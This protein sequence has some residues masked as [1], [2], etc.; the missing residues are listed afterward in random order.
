[1]RWQLVLP[2]FLAMKNQS[3]MS[4]FDFF[5]EGL[6]D[7]RTVGTISRSS[8][9]VSKKMIS[10][11]DFK[12]AK[13]IVELGA[14]DGPITKYILQAMGP[15]TKLLAFEINSKLCE[16]M[17]QRFAGDKRLVVIEDSAENIDKHIAALGFDAADY[18][19][20]ALPFVALPEE[21]GDS[22]LAESRDALRPGGRFIQLNYSLIPRKRY[23]KVFGNSDIAFVPINIP[24]AWVTVC[25][26]K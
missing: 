3:T 2:F 12:T 6:K 14:G 9:F 16:I 20:S 5:M 1:L 7:I 8:K 26:K 23:E 15:D 19:I 13:C 25:E 4:A 18:V 24:P 10:F 22:I 17:R 21:L 11:V